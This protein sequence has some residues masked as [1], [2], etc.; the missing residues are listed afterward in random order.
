MPVHFKGHK[1]E[2]DGESFVL[3]AHTTKDVFCNDMFY[4]CPKL[5]R[6]IL[7][8]KG[9]INDRSVIAD[10]NIRFLEI[11]KQSDLVILEH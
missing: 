11:Y 8:L 9:Y 2:R 5:K 7:P 6:V 3:T 4:Q 10:S 1:L